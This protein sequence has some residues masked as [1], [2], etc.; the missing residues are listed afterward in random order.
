MNP[1]STNSKFNLFASGLVLLAIGLSLGGFLSGK[2]SEKATKEAKVEEANFPAESEAPKEAKVIDGFDAAAEF[3]ERHNRALSPEA[4]EDNR[5]N[6]WKKNFPWKPTYDLAVTVTEDMLS[7][8]PEEGLTAVTHHCHLESFFAS[9]LRYSSQFEQIY[10][11]M[12]KHGR[13]ENPLALAS[14]F[15]TL[16]NYHKASLHDPGE[17][18]RNPDGSPEMRRER[19]GGNTWRPST[20]EYRMESARKTLRGLINS[21][22]DWPH[23]EPLPD[24]IVDSIIEELVNDV[25]PQM[26]GVRGDLTTHGEMVAALGEWKDSLKVGD[27]LMV[28]YEGY[29]AGFDEWNDDRNRAIDEGYAIQMA[30]KQPRGIR[31]DGT[32]VNADGEPIMATEGSFGGFVSDGQR[33]D[34]QE[35]EDGRIRLSPEAMKALAD[36]LG[37]NIPPVPE[38]AGAPPLS[39]EEHRLE[40]VLRMLEEAAQQ[41]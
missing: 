28:P 29:Q 30:K 19:V 7:D 12:E 25:A 35:M 34:L 8:H 21:G 31:A 24:E 22:Y 18:V 40:E 39:E 15:D 4:R 6:L 2:R 23:K 37:S 26:A 38:N 33:F 17:I 13:T 3:R 16:R 27:H 11:I 36:K 14:I 41:Q 5:R 20:W 10:K 9:E 32:L 1:N